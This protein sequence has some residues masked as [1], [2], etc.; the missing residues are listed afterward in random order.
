MPL[1]VQ[2]QLPLGGMRKLVASRGMP[3]G[4]F[5]RA[6]SLCVRGHKML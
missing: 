6:L 1:A 3:I 2:Q 5:A 4:V